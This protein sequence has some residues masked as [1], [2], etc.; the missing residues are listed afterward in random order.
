MSLVNKIIIIGT[1]CTFK[2]RSYIFSS[3]LVKFIICHCRVH[4]KMNIHLSINDII[5]ISIPT[6]LYSN[7]G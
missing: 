3:N 5:K 4:L 7:S 2:N 1:L 6:L